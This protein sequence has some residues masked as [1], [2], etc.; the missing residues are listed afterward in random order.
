[1]RL[2]RWFHTLGSP[3]YVY[4]LATILNP[5]LATATVVL[6]GVG[7]F[8]GLVVV[9]PDYRQGEVYRIIYIHP[10]TAY[11]GMMAYVITAVAAAVGFVWRIKLAHAV[12]VSAAP[13]GASFTFC[14][15]ITGAI[16]GRP[17][18][19]TFWEWGDPRIMSEMLLLFLFLGYLALR[20]AFDD[21]DKAD[22][23]SAILAVVGVVN[24]PIIHYSVEW[25][26][27][28]HQGP[29]VS[30]FDS[31]SMTVDM[32]IP[33]LIMVLGFT[34]CF[35]WLLLNRLRAEI[36]ERERDTR[37]IQQLAAGGAP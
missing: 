35:Y 31:P 17:T 26:N 11:V 25:W 28:L 1:M 30:S 10:Q 8:W 18:W 6:L 36:V 22:R 7:T 20:A 37:W 19:G 34:T 5:W 24:V 13:I 27:T 9:P 2:P 14:A 16:W 23:V 15:L 12:A 4:R 3:P 21:R 29:T 33:F 32:L